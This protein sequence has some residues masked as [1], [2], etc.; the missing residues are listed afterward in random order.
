MAV[1]GRDLDT[2]WHKIFLYNLYILIITYIIYI[3]IYYLFGC[4]S[5]GGS[6]GYITI[7]AMGCLVDKEGLVDD[8]QGVVIQFWEC[9]G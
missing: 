4:F 7:T 1:C 6:G 2:T 9:F 5:T 8:S 3:Y